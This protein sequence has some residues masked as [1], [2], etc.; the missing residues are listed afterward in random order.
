V[1]E[2]VPGC[3][4]VV[5]WPAAM[6]NVFQLMM[7]LLVLWLTWTLALPAPVTVAWPPTTTGPSGPAEPGRDPSTNSAVL[8]KSRVW[9]R[10]AI[11]VLVSS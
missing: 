9:M 7:A 1:T 3:T 8:A 11:L 10:G 4:N 6:L 5:L 2:E